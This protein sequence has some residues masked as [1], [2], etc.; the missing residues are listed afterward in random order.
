MKKKDIEINGGLRK[1]VKK[2]ITRIIE[3]FDEDKTL[4]TKDA[5][6]FMMLADNLEAYH[7]CQ[8]AI[9]KVGRVMT[10]SMGHEVINNHETIRKYTQT[11]IM[12][13]LKQMGLTPASRARLKQND[14]EEETLLTRLLKGD[15]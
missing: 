8:E 3:R 7:E 5:L 4:D 13:I 2:A 12:D 14:G 1:C 10:N 11:F 9:A 6:L 15:D